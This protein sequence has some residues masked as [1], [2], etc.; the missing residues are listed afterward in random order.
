MK[1]RFVVDS[2]LGRLAKWL[3]I[4]GYEAIYR[5]SYRRGEL[6]GLLSQEGR[7]LLTR[8]SE[9]MRRFPDSVF[10][11]S[12]HVGEQLKELVDS[13]VVRVEVDRIFSRCPECGERLI[14]PDPCTAR[15]SLPEYVYIHHVQD[16]EAC[17]SCGRYFWQGSHKQRMLEQLKA[18]GLLR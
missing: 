14:K 11:I 9:N 10:I 7:R 4:L 5:P 6:E 1:E 16:L 2:M 8:S 18:W 15:E 3:R 17:P 13:G 12:D